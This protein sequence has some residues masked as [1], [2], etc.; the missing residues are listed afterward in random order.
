MGG[1]GNAGPRFGRAKSRQMGKG[2]APVD[3]DLLDQIRVEIAKIQERL[4]GGELLAHEQRRRHR[5]QESGRHHGSQRSRRHQLVETLTQSAAANAGMILQEGHESVGQQG[6]WPASGTPPAQTRAQ[7]VERPIDSGHAS[8]DQHLLHGLLSGV[9][10]D[11][12]VA[13]WRAV[14]MPMDIARSAPIMT[15]QQVAM[16]VS[17][18]S[19][20][21]G[22]SQRFQQFRLPSLLLQQRRIQAQ[23]V[24]VELFQPVQRIVDDELAHHRVGRIDTA[25]GQ[26]GRAGRKERRR[27]KVQ[28]IAFGTEVVTGKVQQYHH[29]LV[30]SRLN[31]IFQFVRMAIAGGGRKRQHAVVTP[32]VCPGKSGDRQQ[33]D[34]GHAQFPQVIEPFPNGRKGALRGEGTDVQFVEDRLFPGPAPPVAVVP[35]ELTGVQQL[36]GTVYALG[37]V[38]RSRIREFSDAV[39]PVPVEIARPG[40]IG[41]QFVPAGFPRL[42]RQKNG[43]ARLFQR[44]FHPLRQRRPQAKPNPATFQ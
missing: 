11:R 2:L 12:F 31:Q 28:I 27:V 32:V 9:I 39:D 29:S 13:A 42:H 10:P 35:D 16:T 15:E 43:A 33:L 21:D 36:A 44:H 38:T 14:I 1:V 17:A 4:G 24:E 3:G 8:T 7:L 37:V 34:G 6:I 30:V 41:A 19:L 23:A 5:R 26:T 18:R 22:A 40:P 20:A 25:A